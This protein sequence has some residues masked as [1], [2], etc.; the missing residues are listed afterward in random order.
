[1]S[2]WVAGL[3]VYWRLVCCGLS[4]LPGSDWHRSPHAVSIKSS[5]LGQDSKGQDKSEHS[6]FENC[7]Y[8]TIDSAKQAV[9]YSLLSTCNLN[10][11]LFLGL[12][13]KPM[14]CVVSL[15]ATRKWGSYG[16]ERLFTL[17]ETGK[18]LESSLWSTLHSLSRRFIQKKTPTLQSSFSSS[19]LSGWLSRYGRQDLR[20]GHVLH[21]M[22]CHVSAQEPWVFQL[23]HLRT[24]SPARQ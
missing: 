19:V 10:I 8:T 13:S 20:N 16:T 5:S 17:V 4:S 9:L 12:L 6:D 7:P 11:R 14:P 21:F 22:H 1:M 24:H 23:P 15:N 18:R 2:R 3:I